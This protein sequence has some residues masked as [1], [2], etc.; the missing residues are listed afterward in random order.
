MGGGR[1]VEK[2]LMV[3]LGLCCAISDK[4]LYS[5]PNTEAMPLASTVG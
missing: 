4:T 5:P 3:T 2:G 1:G